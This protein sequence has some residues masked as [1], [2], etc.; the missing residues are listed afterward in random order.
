MERRSPCHRNE[1]RRGLRE[2]RLECLRM[3]GR[4]RRNQTPRRG[5]IRVLASVRAFCGELSRSCRLQTANRDAKSD[6]SFELSGQTVAVA[7]RRI[8]P[9]FSPNLGGSL[10]SRSAPGRDAKRRLAAVAP[11][12]CEQV[13]HPSTA[14][15]DRPA[16]H[17]S[18]Q[19]RV[20]V[21]SWGSAFLR[22]D[23]E[24]KWRRPP[25]GHFAKQQLD[26]DLDRS[27]QWTRPPGWW[28]FTVALPR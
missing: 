13:Q 22:H 12:R 3:S 4:R 17:E 24:E 9:R 1:E 27:V 19:R 16:A 8:R 5:F 11:L 14:L 21:E 7:P 23:A 18:S 26:A 6:N 25:A 2:V 15:F 28:N 10:S 20:K